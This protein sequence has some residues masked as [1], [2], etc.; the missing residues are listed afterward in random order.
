ME[1][2]PKDFFT[3]V[4]ADSV[5][6]F[7]IIETSESDERYRVVEKWERPES[8]G[9]PTWTVYWIRAVAL[10]ER[11]QDGSVQFKQ[12]LSDKQF[13]GVLTL[14]GVDEQHSAEAA[15]A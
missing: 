8:E 11:K 2:Q 6:G 1:H 13:S 10:E 9:G 15:T 14:A 12:Q 5:G 7:A 3:D 4:A